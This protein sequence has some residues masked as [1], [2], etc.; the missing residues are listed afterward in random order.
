MAGECVA[1]L[2]R[3]NP[4]QG[5]SVLDVMQVGE[6]SCHDQACTI[7]AYL[8]IGDQTFG[9]GVAQHVDARRSALRLP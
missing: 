6:G 9:Q 1:H 4:A 2:F 7:Q 5:G 3:Q 8:Q